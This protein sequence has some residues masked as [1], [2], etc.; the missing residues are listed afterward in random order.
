MKTLLLSFVASVLA[1]GTLRADLHDFIRTDPRLD[2][3]PVV[4]SYDQIEGFAAQEQRW[5]RDFKGKYGLNWRI[6]IDV[7]GG[8]PNHVSGQGIAM[9]PGLGNQLPFDH[10]ITE[11]EIKSLVLSF[12]KE[13]ALTFSI[14]PA[15]FQISGIYPIDDF[16]IIN[17]ERVYKRIPVMGSR[18]LMTISHGNIID[19]WIARHGDV[20]VGLSPGIQ[21]RDASSTLFEMI[22][23]FDAMTDT[24]LE[25]GHLELYP[26]AKNGATAQD[27]TGGVG[28]GYDH[29]LVWSITF[30]REGE[31]IWT[32]LVDAHSGQV[33]AF[34]T[35]ESHATTTSSVQGGVY[36][37]PCPGCPIGAKT[38][39]MPYA[40]VRYLY[41]GMPCYPDSTNADHCRNSSNYCLPE[42]DAACAACLAVR[43]SIIFCANSNGVFTHQ[44]PLPSSY[45]QDMNDC[46]PYTLNPLSPLQTRLF[47]PYLQIH[48]KW[49][50]FDLGLKQC[51]CDKS[52][53]PNPSIEDYTHVC[54]PSDVLGKINLDGNPLDDSCLYSEAAGSQT[55]GPPGNTWAARTAFYH[56]NKLKEKWLGTFG[57]RRPSCPPDTGVGCS[58]PEEYG[59]LLWWLTSP[60]QVHV[61]ELQSRSAYRCDVNI[62]V[63]GPGANFDYKLGD[64]FLC[65]ADFYPGGN[66]TSAEVPSILYH[67]M[68]HGMDGFDG[69][70]PYYPTQTHSSEA[71]ADIV[72][73]LMT[74]DSCIA[75]GWYKQDYCYDTYYIDANST[76]RMDHQ[77]TQCNG[78]RD[79]DWNKHNDPLPYAVSNLDSVCHD[80][81][82]DHGI[83][84]KIPYCEG[85]MA[86][87]AFWD[88]AVALSGNPANRQ[89]TDTA[90]EIAD[91]LFRRAV[92]QVGP[93]F[94]AG[95]DAGIPGRYGCDNYDFSPLFISLWNADDND[96]NGATPPPHAQE[97]CDAFGLHEI[98]CN[99]SGYCAGM[100]TPTACPS[101]SSPQYAA[102]IAPFNSG[103]L[104]KWDA[105]DGAYGYDIMRSDLGPNA[106]SV[107]IASTAATE[108]TDQGLLNGQTY[109]YRIVP[110]GASRSCVGPVSEAQSVSP[111]ASLLILPE[112]QDDWLVNAYRRRKLQARGGSGT[113]TWSVFSGSL[114]ND[115]FL[116]SVTCELY[117]QPT[118]VQDKRWVTI[119]AT[120]VSSGLHGDR[121]YR[122]G[123]T[124]NVPWLDFTPT[125]LPSARPYDGNWQNGYKVLLVPAAGVRGYD[126]TVV[127]GALPPGLDCRCEL[128][129]NVYECAIKGNVDCAG[130]PAPCTERCLY[131]FTVRMTGTLGTATGSVDRTFDLPVMENASPALVVPPEATTA[132][133][134]E[135]KV[136]LRTNFYP[137]DTYV[138]F[139]LPP[140]CAGAGC[141]TSIA[142]ESYTITYE[143]GTTKDHYV[144]L[145]TPRFLEGAST[146]HFY[147]PPATGVG[148]AGGDMPLD[149]PFITPAYASSTMAG[150]VHIL[151]T[152]GRDL[153]SP[154]T[155]DQTP[156][157]SIPLGMALSDGSRPGRELYAADAATGDLLVFNASDSRY[158]TTI[159]LQDKARTYYGL[160]AADVAVDSRGYAYVAH[161]TAGLQQ[162]RPAFPPEPWNPDPGGISAVDLAARQLVDVDGNPLEGTAGAPT[163][164]GTA[165]SRI[166]TSLYPYSISI[167]KLER[168]QANYQ[169]GDGWPGEYGFIT[170]VGPQP[171]DPIAWNCFC[172]M[173][174]I[175]LPC[176]SG[177]PCECPPGFELVCLPDWAPRPLRLGILDL[178]PWRVKTPV[179]WALEPNPDYWKYLGG[180]DPG[181]DGAILG[182]SNEG[183]DFSV[184]ADGQSATVYAVMHGTDEVVTFDF[185][186]AVHDPTT[187][188]YSVIPLDC[189]DPAGT[190]VACRPSD[191]KIQKIGGQPYALISAENAGSLLTFPLASPRQLNAQPL[192]ACPAASTATHSPKAVDARGDG[193][194]AFIAD[195]AVGW[196]VDIGGVSVVSLGPPMSMAGTCRI[197]LPYGPD[198]I[199]VAPVST[200]T[201]LAETVRLDLADAA[202]T[203]FTEPVKQDALLREWETVRHLQETR[204]DPQ[205]VAANINNFQRSVNRWITAATLQTD[206]NQAVD[207]YRA[208]YL[209]DHPTSQ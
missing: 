32:G 18:F 84:G 151:D 180:L 37:H 67:E 41:D 72:A 129:G 40:D 193:K 148:A 110:L 181:T 171:P 201:G 99:D 76:P 46:L 51:Q 16:W 81:D 104:L 169:E 73:V 203:A 142:P 183:L 102:P 28:G 187:F 207:L 162:P 133:G 12:L 165:Y 164:D 26:I 23:G 163:I 24:I 100:G 57:H 138:R 175:I 191:V 109:W 60:Q 4:K 150:T 156:M 52:I 189:K 186:S 108:Y 147:F 54:A 149:F 167:L 195:P 127:D 177:E 83:L 58:C 42:K 95:H 68:G 25:P 90:W 205:A 77:C 122:F 139:E 13:N 85:H 130:V 50:V 89:P 3:A 27:Y 179:P 192:Q 176:P 10:E 82:P 131:T 62:D 112:T 9:I 134:T 79:I 174:K 63:D 190:P 74:H 200:A 116:D 196:E 178:N 132:G 172:R 105:A 33:L 125:F 8:R 137:A 44:D 2:P 117:G 166:Q 197:P 64:I 107:R 173:G 19:F 21:S 48:S 70:N 159:T 56:G 152:Y 121:A 92:H 204:A 22:G 11:G 111:T 87:Q 124:S 118:T 153:T 101:I 53:T 61:N 88:F 184:A 36:Y 14:D 39:G 136:F 208:A 113:Y 157:S 65:P 93:K 160:G 49:D 71:Y 141:T 97:L 114:P 154:P 45:P 168:M 206:L 202:P 15:E 158:E 144:T 194:L 182:T 7:R 91:R 155:M 126:F 98:G 30:S 86:T 115:I 1:W 43:H 38:V 209:K 161:V 31:G 5:T 69:T 146:L 103:A 75:R 35:Y 198:R 170:G 119:R 185:L 20:G 94:Y 66:R 106:S 34:F 96:G 120:E 123:V 145:V 143:N 78:F 47:S 55:I 140:G 6:M 17:A 29:L 59:N 199:V 128:V 188:P 135:T 80:A